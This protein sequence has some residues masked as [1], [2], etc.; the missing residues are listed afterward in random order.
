M[1]ILCYVMS[2]FLNCNPGF[3]LLPITMLD[4]LDFS[5]EW[6][7]LLEGQYKVPLIPAFLFFASAI[8]L[9]VYT[10]CLHN[11]IE[12]W[13]WGSETHTHNLFADNALLICQ[14]SPKCNAPLLP[15]FKQNSFILMK[16]IWRLW[17]SPCHFDLSSLSCL[18]ICCKGQS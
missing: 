8:K 1:C 16:W 4:I 2:L 18:T 11:D 7:L 13:D 3:A 15:V 17:M 6:F 10:T 5:Q 9:S 14:F 12:H